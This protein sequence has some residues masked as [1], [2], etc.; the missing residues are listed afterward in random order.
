M[1]DTIYLN[2]DN[3]EV[4]LSKVSSKLLYKAFK[5]KKQVPPTA[6]KKLKEKFPYFSFNWNDIYSL[7]FIVTIETKIREFQYRVLNN[8]VFTNEKMF[9]F[10]MTDSPLYSFLNEKSSLSNICFT[11]VT[12]QRFFGKPSVLGLANLRSNRILLLYITEILFGIFD[13]EDDWIIL[14][15][16]ILIAKYEEGKSLTASL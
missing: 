2:L 1:G 8:M 14:D 10:K 5:S 13:V 12:W 9:K 4:T 16:S 7:P 15:H 6:Q 11:T 3:F